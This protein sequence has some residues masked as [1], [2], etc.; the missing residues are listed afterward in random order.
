VIRGIDPWNKE[1][2]LLF[3]NIIYDV[4]DVKSAK[5]Y[6]DS[7]IV[8]FPAESDTYLFRAKINYNFRDTS[9]AYADFKKAIQFSPDKANCY[10]KMAEAELEAIQYRKCINS[11]LTAY[12]MMKPEDY[13][14]Y[15]L[16]GYSYY[17]IGLKDSACYYFRVLRTPIPYEDIRDYCR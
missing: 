13:H 1:G 4:G 11:C 8:H 14:G 6:I 15:G 5:E 9:A 16:L 17:K 2:C 3:A 12:R 7:L 10:I